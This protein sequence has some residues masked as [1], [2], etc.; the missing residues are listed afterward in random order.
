MVERRQA[1]LE[2]RAAWRA[3]QDGSSGAAHETQD[4]LAAWHADDDID[5]EE[6]AEIEEIDLDK[7]RESATLAR[8][9]EA[10]LRTDA[11]QD[12]QPSDPPPL[13]R[14]LEKRKLEVGWRYI[15]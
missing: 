1:A 8:A 6:L 11:V 15:S 2:R 12:R 10:E 7:L 3:C 9:D 13:D 4:V 14:L 5:A